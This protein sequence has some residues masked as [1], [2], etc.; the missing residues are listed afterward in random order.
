MRYI[1]SIPHVIQLCPKQG[2]PEYPLQFQVKSINGMIWE[3]QPVYK[4]IP[5]AG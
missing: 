4:L 2:F 1:Q 5:N 3:Y